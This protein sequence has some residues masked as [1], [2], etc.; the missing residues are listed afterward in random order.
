MAR[1]DA[2]GGALVASG[3]AYSA[4][5]AFVPAILFLLGIAGLLIADPADRAALVETITEVVPPLREL[6]AISLDQLVREAR[7]VSILGL[8]GLAWGTSRF[9][10]ALE[11]ALGRILGQGTRNFFVRTAFGLGSVVVLVGAVLAGILLAAVT[12]FV[13]AW[14]PIRLDGDGVGDVVTIVGA[15]AAA[16]IAAAAIALVYRF[17]PTGRISWPAILPPSL[18]V[19]IALAVLARAF[20]FLAPRLIG[21]AAVLGTLATVFAALAWLGLSFQAI[22]VGAAWVAERDSRRRERLGLAPIDLGRF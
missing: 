22:L 8:I 1:Y 20:V 3:L 15:I 5:F 18:V 14:I 17:V 11:A 10:L 13:E 4:L 6:L 2:G 9:Y 21:A 16:A 7:S 12:S 19:A